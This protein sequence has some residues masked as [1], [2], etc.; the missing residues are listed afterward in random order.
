VT[1]ADSTIAHA[2]LDVLVAVDIPNAAAGAAGDESRRENGILIVSLCISVASTRDEPV[3]NRPKPIGNL[4]YTSTNH[5]SDLRSSETRKRG[6]PRDELA[7][8]V[9]RISRGCHIIPMPPPNCKIAKYCRR[10]GLLVYGNLEAAV[11]GEG[12]T[13]PAGPA[14]AQVEASDACHHV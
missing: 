10:S 2:I 11:G 8:S 7:N 4:I 5:Q 6:C 14:L 3:R 1:Q 13:V 12:I 9:I